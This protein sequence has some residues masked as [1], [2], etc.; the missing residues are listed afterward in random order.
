MKT[1][2][3]ALL[4]IFIIAIMCIL[5]YVI[6]IDYF[7]TRMISNLDLFILMVVAIFFLALLRTD[8][9]NSQK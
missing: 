1:A 9:K 3:E 6:G 2:I 5:T 8:G 7:N 4:A